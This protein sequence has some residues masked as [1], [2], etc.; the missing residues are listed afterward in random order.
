MKLNDR[1]I[2]LFSLNDDDTLNKMNKFYEFCRLI[3]VT[4]VLCVIST[5]YT[6]GTIKIF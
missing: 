4:I 3:I 5:N 2:E 1:I 6:I